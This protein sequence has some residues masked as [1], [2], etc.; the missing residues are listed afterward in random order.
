[1]AESYRVVKFG[2]SVEVKTVLIVNS[3]DFL[4]TSL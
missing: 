2:Y 3:E 1:M 4:S